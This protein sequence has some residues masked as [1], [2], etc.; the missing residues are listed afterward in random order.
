MLNSSATTCFTTSAVPNFSVWIKP[1]LMHFRAHFHSCSMY[2]EEIFGIFLQ[3][4]RDM[5][6]ATEIYRWIFYSSQVHVF[7]G[8]KIERC[9]YFSNADSNC[10]LSFKRWTFFSVVIVLICWRECLVQWERQNTFGFVFSVHRLSVS[11]GV[12][13]SGCGV[14]VFCTW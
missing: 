11:N 7:D 12:S 10:I 1:H 13:F 14:C 3:L 9:S 5:F 2:I 4:N 8:S 6:M